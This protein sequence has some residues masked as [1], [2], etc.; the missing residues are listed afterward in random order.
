MRWAWLNSTRCPSLEW[1]N[2]LTRTHRLRQLPRS[3]DHAP[4][5]HQPGAGGSARSA[6]QGLDNL[7]PPGNAHGRLRQLPRGILFRGRRQVP[8]L[9]V[10]G[11]EISQIIEY[12]EEAGFQGLGL[13]R[14]RHA[15]AQSPAPRIRVLHR[16]FHPLQRGRLLLGLPHAL[17]AG[18]RGQIFHA[19]C[20]QPAAQPELACGQCHTTPNTWSAA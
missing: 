16:W 18:R 6:G 4:D 5:R 11:T 1:A 9:P 7:H 8:D 15:H 19:R 10:G 12:Y 17:R 2:A 20:P 13:S 3:R 14:N